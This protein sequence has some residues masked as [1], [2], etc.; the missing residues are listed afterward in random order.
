MDEEIVF[1]C[2]SLTAADSELST[3][4]EDSSTNH[5]NVSNNNNNDNNNDEENNNVNNNENEENTI[6]DTNKTS[7]VIEIYEDEVWEII[8]DH[9]KNEI[10]AGM[11]IQRVATVRVQLGMVDGINAGSDDNSTTAVE[12]DTCPICLSEIENDQL[13]FNLDCKHVLHKDCCSNFL[14]ISPE[15]KESSQMFQHYFFRAGKCPTCCVSTEWL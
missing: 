6:N 2:L 10:D 8:P 14:T 9:I 15:Y 13:A 1:D 5:D 3:I 4:I 7:G 12:M 11:E